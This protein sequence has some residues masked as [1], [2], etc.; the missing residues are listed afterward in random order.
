MD[1]ED[2]KALEDKNKKE[3]PEAKDK[4][5]KTKEPP[6]VTRKGRHVSEFV[7]FDDEQD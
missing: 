5:K 7:D 4:K 3:D 6:T 2:Q 1:H